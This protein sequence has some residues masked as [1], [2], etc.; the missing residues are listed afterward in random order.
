[1]I[2][3][4]IVK[5]LTFLNKFRLF[6]KIFNQIKLIENYK[7]IKINKKN[8]YLLDTNFVTNFR[9]NSFFEKE[10]ETIDWINNFEKNSVFWDIGAN[11]GLYSIYSQFINKEIQTVSFE[12]SVLNLDILVKNIFKNNLSEKILIVTNPIYNKST[13]N[14]F[15][16]STLEKGGANSNFG[17]TG[18]N[19]KSIMN[20]K[21]NSLDFGNL[22]KIYGLV[23][24]KYV[25]IDVD[26]NELEILENLLSFKNEIKSI[27]IEINLKKNDLEKILLKNK[28]RNVFRSNTRNNQIWEKD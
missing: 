18:L 17:N 11:V 25:K 27:L 28:F 4:L 6:I 5:F 20:Y 3:L 9:I 16:F 14:K 13:F 8:L 26:G 22:F 21:T 15:H 7:S 23:S 10:P 12:P 1:M 19:R 24:P 2:K